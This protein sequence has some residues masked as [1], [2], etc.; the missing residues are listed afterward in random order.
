MKIIKFTKVTYNTILSQAERILRS[1]G[2]VI[3]P[4][5]TVYGIFADAT[6]EDMIK[7]IFKIK[8]RPEEKAFPIFVKDVAMARKYAYISDAKA[9]FLKKIWPGAVTVVFRHKE[10]LP[11]VLTGGLSTIGVR[12]PNHPFLLEL[13]SRLS[14]PLAQTSANVSGRSP[15]R[16]IQGLKSHNLTRLSLVRFVIDGGDLGGPVSTVIDFTG[17]DPLVLRSGLMTKQELDRI[18]N[19]MQQSS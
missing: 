1:G 14:F 18:L 6:N 7:K 19:S 9:K 17:K 2:I 3:G 16:N 15:A 12:I 11:Q 4:T 10:K 13:L 5:D 8:Q